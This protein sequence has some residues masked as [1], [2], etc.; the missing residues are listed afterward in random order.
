MYLTNLNGDWEHADPT[1]KLGDDDWDT[2][3]W[4]KRP[5]WC[6]ATTVTRISFISGRSESS[7]RI[8]PAE[9]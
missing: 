7:T 3:T 6:S 4:K 9:H 5:T 1:R 2:A 8:P